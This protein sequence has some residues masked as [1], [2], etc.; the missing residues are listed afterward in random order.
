MPEILGNIIVAVVTDP[1]TYTISLTWAHGET[2]VNNFRLLV[3][4]GAFTA[5]TD[6]A[7]FTRVRIGQHGRSLEWP[8]GINF[9]ADDLWFDAH[10]EVLY[11]LIG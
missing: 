11:R 3:D 10:P 1:A 7:F 8:D 4:K 9:G 5:F 2:T 6:P